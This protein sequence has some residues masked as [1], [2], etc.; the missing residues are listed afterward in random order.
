LA[1]WLQSNR[2]KLA[3]LKLLLPIAVAAALV[4]APAASADPDTTPPTLYIPAEMTVEAATSDGAVVNYWSYAIDDTDPFPQ[5]SCSPLSGSVFPV[6]TTTV[7]CTATDLSGN[8]AYGSFPATVVAPLVLGLT[9]GPDAT[10][11]V[12]TGV[13]SLSGTLTCSRAAAGVQLFVTVQQLFARRVLISGTAS[14]LI[15]CQAPST[16]WQVAITGSN[17]RF[18][19]GAADLKA[20][21]FRCYF[22]CTSA[23]PVDRSLR[24]SPH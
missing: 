9:V 24:L 14:P 7:N 19:A 18:G 13:V 4:A 10:V 15:D 8:T 16:A 1:D 11:D 22:V 21:A 5:V 12:K 23:D 20:G 2:R 17:G 6:G 3:M